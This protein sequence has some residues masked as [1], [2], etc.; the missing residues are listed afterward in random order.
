MAK[1]VSKREPRLEIK[2]PDGTPIAAYADLEEEAGILLLGLIPL[3]KYKLDQTM[4]NQI[5]EELTIRRSI[6]TK[7]E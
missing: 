2:F 1:R 4:M 7:T 6:K 3:H 5:T